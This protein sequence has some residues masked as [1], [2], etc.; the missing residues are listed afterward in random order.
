[1]TTKLVDGGALLTTPTMADDH[2]C[3]TLTMHVW[4]NS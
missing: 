4:A 2:R 3:Y 1:M